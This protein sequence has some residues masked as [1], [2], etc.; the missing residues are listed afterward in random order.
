MEGMRNKDVVLDLVNKVEPCLLFLQETWFRS[1][2]SYQISDLV[3]GYKWINKTADEHLTVEDRL[4]ATNLG[5]HGVS[6]GIKEEIAEFIHEVEVEDRGIICLKYK[7]EECDL[8][9]LNLYLP[10]S[11]KDEEFKT[12]L[13]EITVCLNENEDES[14]KTL[15]LGDLNVDVTRTE[16]RN[17]VWDRFLEEH[18]LEDHVIGHVT[19]RHIREKSTTENELDRVVTKGCS[20]TRIEIRD[21]AG[22]KSA[23]TPLVVELKIEYKEEVEAGDENAQPAER[24]VPREVL[25]ENEQV[26]GELTN[27]VAGAV[28]ELGDVPM[29][30]KISLV[31]HLLYA[32]A[33]AACGMERYRKSGKRV[34]KRRRYKPARKDYEDLRKAGLELREFRMSGGR[35]PSVYHQNFRVAKARVTAG[36][37][38]ELE[39]EKREASMK[40]VKAYRARD[41]KIFRVLKELKGKETTSGTPSTIKGYGF[42]FSAPNVLTGFARLYEI[43][44]TLDSQERYEEQRFLDSRAL[45][46]NRKETGWSKDELK[47]TEMTDGRYTQL[48]RNLKSGKAQDACG[49][50]NDMLKLVGEDMKKTI[51]GICRESLERA[52]FG[53]LVTNTGKGSLLVKKQNKPKDNVKNW[54]NVVSNNTIGNVVQY[55]IQG[56]V[57]ER[58]RDVQTE[59]QLGF[60]RGIPITHAIVLRE[61][62]EAL[63]D[64]MGLTLFLGVLDLKSCFPRICRENLLHLCAEILTPG[65]WSVISQI[66]EGTY[67]EIRLDG[68]KSEV[69]YRDS[70]TI[71][72]GVLSVQLL[73]VYLA[74]LLKMLEDAGYKCKVGYD[75]LVLG[76]GQVCVADDVLLFAFDRDDLTAMLDICETWSNRYRAEFSPEKSVVVVRKGARSKDGEDSF[77]LY[78]EQL[79]VVE[80]A[81]HLG[82]PVATGGGSKLLVEER[83]KKARRSMLSTISYFDPAN[84][85]TV[86]IKIDLWKKVYLSTLLYGLNTARLK[87]DELKKVDQF[88]LTTLKAILNIGRKASNAKVLVLCGMMSVS[89]EIWRRR[90]SELSSILRVGTITKRYVLMNLFTKNKKSW[91]W[92]TILKLHEMTGGLELDLMNFL[93]VSKSQ[94]KVNITNMMRGEETRRLVASLGGAERCF[95]M[96]ADPFRGPRP[97]LLSDFSQESR[98]EVRSFAQVYAGDFWRQYKGGG[99][100]VCDRHDVV[101]N[102]EHLLGQGCESLAVSPRAQE[103]WAE[104]QNRLLNHFESHPIATQVV[105]EHFRVRFILD[106]TSQRLGE[107]RLTPELLQLGGFDVL[108]RKF[109]HDRLTRRL[110]QLSNRGKLRCEMSVNES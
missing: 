95:D 88:Q 23:H 39:E 24:K 61:E 89:A 46:R 85:L 97:M 1:F 17:K 75:D 105:S 9:L 29:D 109:V 50:S 43:Q 110:Q 68:K 96:P 77:Y 66:Y 107:W 80:E 32:C 58:V 99:C 41:P 64:Q 53:G 48:V 26:Y 44:G 60:T 74:V 56:Q 62:I 47:I 49:T 82:V 94:S 12:S 25:E 34:K 5:F 67:Q 92:K 33:L 83:I 84:V 11:G 81:E 19:H 102:A 103:L 4:V 73:K 90:L 108:I 45:I 13:D 71:E 27:S 86:P 3:P 37:K 14:M 20:P 101:D 7:T 93:T 59:Y 51:H 57:E 69:F 6:V 72:G 22:N 31:S 35:P 76:P 63:A 2:N 106:P 55:H 54:R 16:P 28:R 70:G 30:Y 87:A 42:S 104:V 98:V 91:S 100:L 10:T 78:G 21:V 38:K 36:L 15:M 79:L 40:V 8:M 18:E 65:Q 52:E